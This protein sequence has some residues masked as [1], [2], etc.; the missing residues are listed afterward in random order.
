[1]SSGTTSRP[2]PFPSP[3]APMST[4]TTAERSWGP[5]PSLEH[6]DRFVSRHVGPNPDDA[7][8]MLATLGVASL[9]ALVAETVPSAIRLG[10]AL[11]LPPA[12]TEH[13]ALVALRALASKN[14]V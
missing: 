3:A 11:A 12:K 9:D 7:K 4:T 2:R 13:E 1:R 14:R 5:T 10:R 8:A 6:P